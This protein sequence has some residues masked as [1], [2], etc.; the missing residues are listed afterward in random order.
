VP[1]LRAPAPPDAKALSATTGTRQ[2][3]RTFIEQHNMPVMLAGKGFA[4]TA[5]PATT[6]G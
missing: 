6:L 1:R 4:C 3:I 2:Q 5:L